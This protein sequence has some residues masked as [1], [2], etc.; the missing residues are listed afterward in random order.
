MCRTNCW[1]WFLVVISTQL[2][3]LMV[4]YFYNNANNILFRCYNIYCSFKLVSKNGSIKEKKRKGVEN[5]DFFNN[6]TL[7]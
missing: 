6:I 1:I 4:N 3:E 2:G 5:A 7:K